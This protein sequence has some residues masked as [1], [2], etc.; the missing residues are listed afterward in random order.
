MNHQTP[1]EIP[2]PRHPEPIDPPVDPTGPDLPPPKEDPP[3][4]HPHSPPPTKPEPSD[5]QKAPTITPDVT[6]ITPISEPPIPGKTGDA[7]S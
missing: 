4:E 2:I 5:P 1:D 6:P 3:T 7:T